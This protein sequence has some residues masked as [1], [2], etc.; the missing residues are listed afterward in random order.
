MKKLFKLLT[1]VLTISLLAACT[2]EKKTAGLP[3][4]LGTKDNPVKIGVV[5]EDTEV[6]DGVIARLQ[7]QDIYAEL[8]TFTDYNQP[9]EALLSGDLQLNS[10]QHQRFLDNFNKEKGS[11]IVSIGDT[12]LAPLG[13]YSSKI[14]DVSEIKNGDRIA[15]PDDVSNG[16]RALILLQTAGLIKVNGQAGDDLT[17]DDITENPLNLEIIA[18]DASQTARSLDDVTAAAINNGMAIDAGYIPTKDS[19][20]LEPVDDNSKPY[21]NIIATKEENKDNEVLKKIAQAYQTDETAKAID[22][23]TK[24]SSIPAWK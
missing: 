24:G 23:T 7:E 9:N 14:K 1:I 4:N 11:N 13:L 22:E 15:I 20:F 3:E 16:S 8:V 10:F 5:G 18:L 12:V 17:K 19:F 2:G 21:I 6:W